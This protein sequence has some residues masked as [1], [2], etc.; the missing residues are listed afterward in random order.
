MKRMKVLFG[1]RRVMILATLAILVLAAAALAASSA[2]FNSTSANPGNTF[3]TGNLHHT[4]GVAGAILS[5]PSKMKPGD[6][7]SGTVTIANDGDIGGSSFTLTQ[8]SIVP[9][10]GTPTFARYLQLTVTDQTSS[11]VV[12]GPAAFDSL[13]TVNISVPLGSTHTFKFDVLF[14]NNATAGYENQYKGTTAGCTFDWTL[15][16]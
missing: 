10:A 1:Q 5:V 2:S 13:G 8:S 11:T 7:S 15:S 6:T 12:Y 14:P 16:Q 4:N 3:T 9:G